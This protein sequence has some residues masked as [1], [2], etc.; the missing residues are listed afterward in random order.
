MGVL[1]LRGCYVSHF[2]RANGALYKRALDRLIE[3]NQSVAEANA[4]T[5]PLRIIGSEIPKVY[6]PDNGSRS[7][8]DS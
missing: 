6:Y 3:G 7:E 2:L 1:L 5:H 8:P 4:T